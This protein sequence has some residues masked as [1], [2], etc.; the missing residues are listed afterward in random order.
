MN[1][2]I[3]EIAD[4][5]IKAIL[6]FLKHHGEILKQLDEAQRKLKEKAEQWDNSEKKIYNLMN[7]PPKPP[8]DGCEFRVFPDKVQG[9]RRCGCGWI[10]L[11]IDLEQGQEA[12]WKLEAVKKYFEIHC[13]RCDAEDC[14]GC[15]YATIRGLTGMEEKAK[16]S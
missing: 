9:C 15:S 7:L 12:Q 5:G 11:F 6:E 3:S 14:F 4:E 13:G 1:E 8:C 16:P 10:K 2:Y